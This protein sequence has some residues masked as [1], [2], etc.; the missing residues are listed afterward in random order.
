MGGNARCGVSTQSPAKRGDQR[1]GGACLGIPHQH[2]ELALACCQ[3]GN[4]QMLEEA[5]SFG[6][7]SGAVPA[8]IAMQR[9]SSNSTIYL[10]IKVFPL[11]ST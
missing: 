11:L 8:R 6:E 7:G 1:W 4:A 9:Q 10:Q 2:G 5:L 3:D